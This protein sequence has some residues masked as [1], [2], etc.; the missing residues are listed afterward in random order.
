[1]TTRRGA[2]YAGLIGVMVALAYLNFV[3]PTCLGWCERTHAGMIDG[4][5]EAPFR[6]RLLGAHLAEAM[7]GGAV[8]VKYAL[9]HLAAAPFAFAALWVWLRGEVGGQLALM[10]CWVM[11]AYMLVFFHEYSLGIASLIEV[12]IVSTGLIWLRVRG[13]GVGYALLVAAGTLNR[14]TTGLLLVLAVF[15][16]PPAPLRRR[17][18][19]SAGAAFAA[20]FV[21]LRLM[22]G[23]GGGATVSDLLRMNLYPHRLLL[24]ALNHLPLLVVV[25][26]TATGWR[27][28]SAMARRRLV[29]MGL[30]YAALV[31]IFGLWNEVRLWM[32]VVMLALPVM[33]HSLRRASLDRG[34][35]SA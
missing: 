22:L 23:A 10:G 29:I 12:G 18:G 2:V 35:Q 21:G 9:A 30:P 4:T 14:E 7:P 20:V 33:L 27:T 16:S 15:T 31:L 5:A 32:P 26:L 17:G 1:M 25:G 34:I 8:G 6:Y 24:A 28:G 11:A 19:I 13:A 3:A